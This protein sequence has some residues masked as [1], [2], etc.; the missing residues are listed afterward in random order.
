MNEESS[1]S[2]LIISIL[3]DILDP[4]NQRTTKGKISLIDLAGSER[5]NKANST[6]K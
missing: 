4:S 1:R 3:I 2:H 6:S 5:A